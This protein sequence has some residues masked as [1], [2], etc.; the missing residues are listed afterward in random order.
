MTVVEKNRNKM[1]KAYK[2]LE[3]ITNLVGSVRRR[4]P[5]DTPNEWM[6]WGHFKQAFN[7]N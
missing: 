2:Q 3:L 6:A 7:L 5:K 4:E 1:L